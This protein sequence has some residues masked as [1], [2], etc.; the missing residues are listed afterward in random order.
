MNTY[1]YIFTHTYIYVCI[2]TFMHIYTY[3]FYTHQVAL[4][5][6]KYKDHFERELFCRKIL[7]SQAV[8]NIHDGIGAQENVRHIDTNIIDDDIIEDNIDN[9]A[10][11]RFV[12]GIIRTHNSDEDERFKYEASIKGT[13]Y[14]Y[15]YMLIYIYIYS[16]MYMYMY[17]YIYVYVCISIYLY[18]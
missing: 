10:V 7:T 5:F 8:P 2:Y 4:K 6:M 16:Y 9:L 11:S 12:L 18:I 17:I 3:S 15:I 13:L 1:V 14:I